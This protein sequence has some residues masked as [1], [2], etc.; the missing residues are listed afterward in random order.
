MCCCCQME[1][2][3]APSFSCCRASD[4]HRCR[5][6]LTANQVPSLSRSP[7]AGCDDPATPGF[8]CFLSCLHLL[9]LPPLPRL[10]TVLTNSVRKQSPGQSCGGR[11]SSWP[12]SSSHRAWHLVE[13]WLTS[14][15]ESNPHALSPETSKGLPFML[16]GGLAPAF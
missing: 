1:P 12:P 6:P 5:S 14:S 4:S 9:H 13:I 11:A 2:P 7:S 15:D 10:L 3:R 8:P 16:P